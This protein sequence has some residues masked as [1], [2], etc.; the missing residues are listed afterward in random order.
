MKIG[1]SSGIILFEVIR[2]GLNYSKMME[3][4]MFGE[5]NMKNMIYNV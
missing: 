2:L 4:N 5:K 1:K 3:E